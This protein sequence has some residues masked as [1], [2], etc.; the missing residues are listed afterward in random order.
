MHPTY[1]KDRSA[2]DALLTTTGDA[3]HNTKVINTPGQLVAI[4]FE[5]AFDSVNR[6]FAFNFCVF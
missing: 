3:V 4:D 1:A 6:N 5:K 2:F